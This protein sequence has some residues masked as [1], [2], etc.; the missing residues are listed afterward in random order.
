MTFI[1]IPFVIARTVFTVNR[2]LSIERAAHPFSKNRKYDNVFLFLLFF[3]RVETF[4]P[5]QVLNNSQSVRFANLFRIGN[6]AIVSLL[7]R[8][9][10]PRYSK[11]YFTL[12]LSFSRREGTKRIEKER[13]L[14]E[15]SI[16]SI[17]LD[18]FVTP[19][20][21]GVVISQRIAHSFNIV[22]SIVSER[23]LEKAGHFFSFTRRGEERWVS[24]FLSSSNNLHSI[25]TFHAG[26]G[27][28]EGRDHSPSLKRREEEEVDRVQVDAVAKQA[29]TPT[30]DRASQHLEGIRE[31]ATLR[32]RCVAWKPRGSFQSTFYYTTCRVHRP[33][34]VPFP[35]PFVHNTPFN[36]DINVASDWILENYYRHRFTFHALLQFRL[37]KE[38]RMVIWFEKGYTKRFVSLWVKRATRFE[39]WIE[40]KR[41]E[42]RIE[43]YDNR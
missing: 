19:V 17:S 32:Q 28:G 36:A 6:Q 1:F 31:Q 39:G 13:G 41:I 24:R 35:S 2:V 23:S 15:K 43:N 10:F 20:E 21:N 12:S 14:D 30:N 42:L 34:I 18:N 9:K 40:R 11:Q 7:E 38:W 16:L 3:F 26:E 25:T 22:S 37:W 27:K 29:L 4:F 8:R 5:K 33:I